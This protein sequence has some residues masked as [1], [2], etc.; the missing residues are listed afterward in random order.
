MAPAPAG[1][2]SVLIN[3]WGDIAFSHTTIISAFFSFFFFFFSFP[4][5]LGDL[6]YPCV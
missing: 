2:D 5:Y 3:I 1:V 4:V 6:L